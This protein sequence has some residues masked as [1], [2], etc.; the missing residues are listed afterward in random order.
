MF[1]RLTRPKRFRAGW[2]LALVYLLCV[3]AP[4]ISFAFADGSRAAPCLTDENHGLGIV[5]VHEY[6]AGA[7]QHVVHKDGHVHDHS[8]TLAHF[9]QSDS[10]DSA[11]S[12]TDET[13]APANGHH[14]ASGTPCCGMVCLSALPATVVDIVKPF[15]PTS[16]CDSENYR[17]VADS[18]PPRHYRPP[19][20]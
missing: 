8:G 9:G 10:S 11:I 5:H 19:I 12:V 15:A 7:S 16:V 3:L 14:K 4:G 1:V 13:P 6:S 17:N 2:L 18:A 20:S